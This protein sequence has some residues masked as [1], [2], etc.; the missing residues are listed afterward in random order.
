[1]ESDGQATKASLS[2]ARSRR[3]ARRLPGGDAGRGH[4]RLQA[5][6]GL[7]PGARPDHEEAAVPE[8]FAAVE[9]TLGGGGVGLFD[10][11]RDGLAAIGAVGAAADVAVAG[12]GA[13]GHDAEGDD[14]ALE[15]RRD[16]RVDGG[17]E[18]GQIGD[19]VVGRHHQHHRVGVGDRQ[20]GQREGRRG[21]AAGRLEHDVAAAAPGRAQLLGGDEAVFLVAHHD[22]ADATGRRPAKPASRPAVAC[23]MVSLPTR[24]SSC[25]GY[26]SRESGHR[27]V[28]E[29]PERMT[30]WSSME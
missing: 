18:A 9:V 22:G 17:L 4:R 12:L 25:L 15:G 23:S 1:M 21:V 10:E 16:A 14:G 5:V 26:C 2:T 30:G 20:G 6:D 11:G 19:D 28:P 29:P 3:P 27:R 13:V 24:A 7:Q 8:V